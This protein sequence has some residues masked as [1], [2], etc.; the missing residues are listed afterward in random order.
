MDKEKIDIE[1]L[2][3]DL[4]DMYGAG[5]PFI[6]AMMMEVVDL[7]NASDEEILEE[8]EDNKID[9]TKYEKKR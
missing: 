7:E 9:L 5:V 6:P 2:R 1:K 3:E 4:M 8:A